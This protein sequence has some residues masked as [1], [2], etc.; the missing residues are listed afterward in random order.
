MSCQ[1]GGQRR[2]AGLETTYFDVCMHDIAL[3][4]MIE[5]EKHLLGIGP[6][7]AQVESHVSAEPLDHFAEVH[8][9]I[10]REPQETD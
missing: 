3:A 2:T 6:D 8:A 4:K 1:E 5:G 10:L 7:G 9:G